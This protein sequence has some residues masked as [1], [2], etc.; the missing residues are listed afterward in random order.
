MREKDHGNACDCEHGH[1]SL[2]PEEELVE[3][4][5]PP[6]PKEGMTRRSFLDKAIKAG[7]AGSVLTMS[8]VPYKRGTAWAESKIPAKYWE[9]ASRYGEPQGKHGKPGDPIKLTIGYQP[10]C[11]TCQSANLTKSGEIWKKH[12][13][14]GS[15]VKWFR[16]LSGPL[17]NNN[18]VAGKNQYGYMCDTPGLRAMETVECITLQSAGYDTGEH[19]VLVV[20]KDLW[21]SGKVKS[22]EQLDG[23]KIGVP[24][25][26]FSHRQAL[27]IA[28]QFNIRPQLLDQ[29]T[30]L[31]VTQ[32]RAKNIDACVTWE[33]YPMYLEYL[34]I[35]IRLLTGQEMMDTCSQYYPKAKPHTW[36]TVCTTL[37]ITPWLRDRPDAMMNWIFAEEEAREIGTRDIDFATYLIWKDIPEFP[38]SVVRATID[39]QVWDSGIVFREPYGGDK[40]YG[41]KDVTEGRNHFYG[42]THQWRDMGVLDTPKSADPIKFIDEWV[43]DRW[44]KLAYDEMKA[45][46]RWTGAD[47]P[48]HFPDFMY[49]H[50]ARRHDWAEYKDIKLKDNPNW[51]MMGSV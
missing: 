38:Q 9:L 12:F 36:R 14:E 50:Q 11:L 10:Y 37:A 2:P 49:A 25:G 32:M 13:P 46:G 42:I 21:D 28:Y 19:G 44:L 41:R 15:K 29:S 6:K 26:S 30:E 23:A 33:P 34:G 17:I 7:I 20:R 3:Y 22:P 16:S 8:Q 27:D 39:M 45:K 48:C 43:D 5:N 35:G 51:K 4:V 1:H 31:Q 47:L 18:M 24:L 40:K